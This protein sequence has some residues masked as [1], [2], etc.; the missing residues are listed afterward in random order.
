MKLI[1]RNMFYFLIFSATCLSTNIYAKQVANLD[2]IK[3]WKEVGKGSYVFLFK[4]RFKATLK[5][6]TLNYK[7]PSSEAAISIRYLQSFTKQDLIEA[8]SRSWRRMGES[9]SFIANGEK[10]LSKIYPNVKEN[11]V[12]T[13]VYQPGNSLF[14]LNRK[15]IG[16][17]KDNNFSK[18]FLGIWLSENSTATRLRRSLLKNAQ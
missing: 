3:S 1:L 4:T 11:D 6:P 2:D 5:S 13:F 17:I 7:Y 18:K 12:I 14:F 15:K 10:V 16:M 9:P 8:T